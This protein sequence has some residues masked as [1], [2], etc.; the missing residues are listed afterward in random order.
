[1][2][3]YAGSGKT[4]TAVEFSRWYALTGGIHGPVLFTSFEQ[5]KPLKIVLTQIESCFNK[6]ME[7]TGIHW[8]A[9][10][11]KK[12]RS[13][14]LQLLQQFPIL[15]VWDNVESVSG[16]SERTENNLSISEQQELYD[17]LDATRYTKAKFLLTS[18][19]N[20]A[21]WLGNLVKQIVVPPM[22][23]QERLQLAKTLVE[24]F[25]GILDDFEDWWPLLNYTQGNPLTITVLVGQVVQ[26]G[27]KTKEEIE[28][29]I[30]NLRSGE[31]RFDDEQSE[32]R[33]KSLGAS[34]WRGFE[35]VFQK[36]ELKTIALLRLF[37]EIIDVNTLC[38]MGDTENKSSLSELHGLT[39]E[40]CSNILDRAAAVG[41]LTAL[42]DGCYSIHPILPWYFKRLFDQY[43]PLSTSTNPQSFNERSAS[44]AYINAFAEKSSW[45]AR[46]FD[47]GNSYAI[48]VLQA[49]EAN[50]LYAQKIS[51]RQAKWDCV[52]KITDGLLIL[53]KHSGRMGDCEQLLKGII[54]DFDDQESNLPAN[55]KED[56]RHEI[57]YYRVKL[58]EQ[59]MHWEEAERL[60]NEQVEWK[61]K[62]VYP[63]LQKSVNS[64]S[65][66]DKNLIRN[67]S[68]S[69]HTLGQI[70]RKLNKKECLLHYELSYTLANK[71]NEKSLASTCAFNLGNA[72]SSISLIK[73][74]DQAEGW[75]LRSLDLLN[76]EDKVLRSKCFGELGTVYRDRALEAAGKPEQKENCFQNIEKAMNCYQTG[77]SLIPVEDVS[78]LAKCHNQIANL[79]L[80][81]HSYEDASDYYIKAIKYHEK[82][83]DI[84][85]A[86]QTRLNMSIAL[87][88][89]C[90]F[91][92]AMDYAQSALR[93]Y[94]SI[95]NSHISETGIKKAEKFITVISGNL[96][97]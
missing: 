78:T 75:Y 53:Y 92:E 79:H 61:L 4:A 87:F 2:H 94:K 66:S 69:L 14:A 72:Y 28:N 10:D 40:K 50:L 76:K 41:L 52:L 71:I 63:I 81:M 5:A 62:N 74:L 25:G 23:M 3:A 24:K 44:M 65:D 12:R 39:M 34:L 42:N 64:L 32:G 1:M 17:F 89:R 22:P 73:N 43:Y 8:L 96:N 33:A 93:G 59:A 88:H 57:N 16:F 48:R 13:V 77:L 85:S 21:D 58:A 20:E 38:Y 56:L 68:V 70:R 27:L 84:Y 60:Q 45:F 95:T 47:D 90:R 91:E 30:D 82:A 80:Y 49:D 26:E 15:W 51:I 46:L 54:T 19:S 11:D 55:E 86:A 36:E 6:T 29:F 35:H 67:T 7:Q 83:E 18:R 97:K 9:L 31:A 37:Q